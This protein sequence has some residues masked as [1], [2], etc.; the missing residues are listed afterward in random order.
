MS[1]IQSGGNSEKGGKK[2]AKKQSTRVDMTPLVDL[3]FLLLT[4]FVLTSTFSQPKVLRMIF[5]EKLDPKNK[6]IKQPEVKDGLT[7]LLSD[8]DK[9][10]WYRGALNAKTVLEETDYTKNGLRKVL[11]ENN[12]P[13]LT[14][15]RAFEKELNK[16]DLKDTAKRSAIDIKVKEAQRDSKLV[17]LLKNDDKATYRNVIDVMDEF[18]IT[19]IA[20]YFAVDEGMAGL[21][22][23]L[24][25]QK[26]KI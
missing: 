18:M 20:K 5:P 4:F 1:E 21:E 26:I 16:I 24:I 9:I 22:K 2:R 8:N 15:L 19:Q 25:T 13:L 23:K 12:L 10:F 17:V 14:Q 7:I 11:V 3:A 6:D